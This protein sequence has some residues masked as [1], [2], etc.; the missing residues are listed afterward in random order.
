[1]HKRFVF[2][3]LSIE[4]G[5]TSA[6]NH[7]IAFL[8]PI[9]RRHF[10]D[11]VCLNVRNE[12]SAG[13]FRSRIAE[14][15]PEIVGFSC[16]SH[17]LKYLIKYS[18]AI[19]GCSGILQIAGGVAATLDPEFILS[20][21]SATGTCIGEAEIPLDSLLNNISRNNDIFSTDGFWWRVDGRIKKNP[22]SQFIPNLSEI[23]FPDYTIFGRNLVVTYKGELLILLSRGCPYNCY[24]CCNKALQSVYPP[25]TTKRYFRLPSVNYSITLLERMLQLYSEAEFIYFEDDLLIADKAWFEDFAEEYHKRINLP[26]KMN[27]RVEYVTPDIVKAAKRSG[28]RHVFV[29][30]ESGNEQLRNRLLNRKYTNRLFVEKCRMIKAAGLELFTFNIVGFPFEGRIEMEDTLRL[31]KR[32]R[33]NNGICTFFYPYKGTQL[34]RIC[35]K[36]NLL[37]PDNEMIGI[38]NYNTR[39]AIR[40]TPA[41]E[42]CCIAFQERIL[43][44]LM[45]RNGLTEILHLPPGTR[46]YVLIVSYQLGTALR[47]VPILYKVVKGIY[48]FSGVEMLIRHLL[49]TGRNKGIPR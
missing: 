18:K 35:E 34:Y 48:I 19:E 39:P 30:L 37:M 21:S 4:C 41:K 47:T 6:I 25:D 2:V 9:V 15:D 24:Y 13:E 16:T 44:Y 43:R 28:C 11:V 20:E 36:N 38:T 31:N 12:I 32:V 45:K 17:Q 23:E 29:G 49:E 5:Y 40:M 42:K 14:L 7:G 27:A 22:V 33:P 8:A 10:Y 3:N 46:K 1:M 26:Y